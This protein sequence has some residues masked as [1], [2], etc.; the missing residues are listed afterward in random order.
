MSE[1]NLAGENLSSA[2]NTILTDKRTATYN[3]KI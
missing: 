1:A 2:G 3:R